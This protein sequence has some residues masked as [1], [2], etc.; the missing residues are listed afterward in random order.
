MSKVLYQCKEC[1]GKGHYTV[2]NAYDVAYQAEHPCE[3]CSESGF[4][5]TNLEVPIVKVDTSGTGS[6][7]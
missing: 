7:N 5:E 2:Y 1:E 3:Y 6:S 4:V